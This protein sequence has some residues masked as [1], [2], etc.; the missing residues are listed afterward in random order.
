MAP[1]SCE[2]NIYLQHEGFLSEDSK[3]VDLKLN[4]LQFRSMDQASSFVLEHYN[5][6][7]FL[8]WTLLMHELFSKNKN[9]S[10]QQLLAIQEL[11]AIGAF[12]SLK[13]SINLPNSHWDML[14]YSVQGASLCHLLLLYQK[15]VYSNKRKPKKKQTARKIFLSVF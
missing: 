4:S 8:N 2:F 10:Y 14:L 5:Q 15:T 1:I 11:G 9:C 6:T 13:N 12:I 3:I 7:D